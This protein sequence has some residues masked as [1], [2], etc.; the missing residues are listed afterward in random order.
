[1]EREPT[2]RL[3]SREVD[4]VCKGSPK[5]GCTGNPMAPVAV[6]ECHEPP[7]HVP[8]L[9][10]PGRAYAKEAGATAERRPSRVGVAAV[11]GA[12]FL[13]GGAA[14]EP[15]LRGAVQDELDRAGDGGPKRS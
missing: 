7:V 4:V 5:R 2:T 10:L 1:M 6:G 11:S 15:S 3:L 9:L 12:F 8:F 14:A 13:G